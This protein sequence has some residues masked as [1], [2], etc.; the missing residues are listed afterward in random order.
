MPEKLAIS[1]NS[2]LESLI[3]SKIIWES[4]LKEPPLGLRILIELVEILYFILTCQF[5]QPVIAIGREI[6]SDHLLASH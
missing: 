4:I 1:Q 2:S 3:A 5:L 6:G